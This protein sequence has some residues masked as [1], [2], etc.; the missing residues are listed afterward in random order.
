MSKKY[1]YDKKCLFKYCIG[2]IS[3]TSALPIPLCIKLPQMNGYVKYFD[4]K[5]KYMNLL[6]HNKEL[7]KKIQCDMVQ[8]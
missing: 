6:V 1:L 5:N 8:D 4:S 7:L 2:Y 3:E